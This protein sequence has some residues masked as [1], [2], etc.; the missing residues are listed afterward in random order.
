M[1]INTKKISHRRQKIF[2]LSPKESSS[3]I[4]QE[5]SERPISRSRITSHSAF[6]GVLHQTSCPQTLPNGVTMRN[7]NHILDM[8]RPFIFA[9]D[10]YVLISCYYTKVYLMIMIESLGE[11]KT[12]EIER[13]RERERNSSDFN[14]L[15][16][17]YQNVWKYHH[18]T[19]KRE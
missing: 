19:S 16:L 12:R 6:L 5:S 10:F 11:R 17:R 4:F 3:R 14:V 8:T 7:G 18:G 15:S 1:K 13:E 9:M 2:H